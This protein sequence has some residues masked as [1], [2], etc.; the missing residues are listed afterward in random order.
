VWK[1]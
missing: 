1:N